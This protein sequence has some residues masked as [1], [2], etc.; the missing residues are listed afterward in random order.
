[1]YERLHTNC[2]TFIKIILNLSLNN[3]PYLSNHL[4][5]LSYLTLQT[6][7]PTPRTS[8]TVLHTYLSNHLSLLSYLTLQTYLPTPRTS[9]TVATTA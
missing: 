7:L 4:S 2:K 1:M 5:L 8:S 3:I 9:G 6:Y